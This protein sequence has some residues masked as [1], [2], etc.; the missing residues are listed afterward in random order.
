[1]NTFAALE[2]YFDFVGSWQ[3]IPERSKYDVGVPPKSYILRIDPVHLEP[4]QFKIE[5]SWLTY[6]NASYKAEALLIADGGRNDIQIENDEAQVTI[7]VL[8]KS[9]MIHTAYSGDSTLWKHTYTIDSKGY[10]VLTQ[11]IYTKEAVATKYD[12][13]HKQLSVLPYASSVSGVAI[14]PTNEGIIKHKALQAMAEQTDMH[15]Q[16]I[17]DQIE[18]LAKQAHEIQRRKELSLRIYSSKINFVP[19]IGQQYHLY[20]KHNGEYLLSLVAPTEWGNAMPF[21]AFTASV[22]LLAD[23]TWT[24]VS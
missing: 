6:D 21:K 12:V 23:H 24:E 10:L 22:K 15:L 2:R 7:D 5:Q 19:Q 18:L 1:M 20:E 14:V 16:Q 3:L 4:L 9:T 11:E 13:F 17:K 8:D